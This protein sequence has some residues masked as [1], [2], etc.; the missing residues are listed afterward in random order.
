MC[1]QYSLSDDALESLK[2]FDDFKPQMK[3]EIIVSDFAPV[4]TLQGKKLKLSL[5]RFGFQRLDNTYLYNARIETVE[6]KN[7]FKDLY[8]K[9]RCLI[10]CSAFYEFDKYQ[11]EHRFVQANGNAFYLLGLYRD[12][13]FVILTIK[14]DDKV[15]FYHPRM[16][17]AVRKETA[18]NFLK[19]QE[20]SLENR[21][22][23][24]CADTSEMIPLF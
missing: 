9:N 14:G 20:F 10:P 19:G 5:K 21:I 16:P 2:G 6:E 7:T 22:S 8:Q 3:N 17:I 15:S 4:F 12:D 18:L 13:S 1:R 11:K 23:L 24:R